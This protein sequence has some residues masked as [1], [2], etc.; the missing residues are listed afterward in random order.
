V[1][2]AVLAGAVAAAAD[3][4]WPNMADMMFPKM[5]IAVLLGRSCVDEGWARLDYTT[6]DRPPS[7]LIAQ[8]VT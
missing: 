8:P 7:T 2:G 4:E 5:L 1:A 6:G 3:D